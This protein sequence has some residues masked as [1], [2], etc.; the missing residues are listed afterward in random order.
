[1]NLKTTYHD[2]AT[3]VAK[4]DILLSRIKNHLKDLEKRSLHL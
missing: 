4:I 1:M 3:I 2:D